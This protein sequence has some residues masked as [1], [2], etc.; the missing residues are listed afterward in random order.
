MILV[1]IQ[2][3][4]G[5]L[6]FLPPSSAPTNDDPNYGTRDAILA[7]QSVQTNIGAVGG[8]PAKVTVGGESA[9]A[10]LIRCAWGVQWN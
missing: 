4:L 9:G 8:D 3:R 2:Y 6:G 5:V 1:F 7:L 10:S